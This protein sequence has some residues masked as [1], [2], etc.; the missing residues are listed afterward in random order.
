M[1]LV[2]SSSQAAQIK[3]RRLTRLQQII[4]GL[5]KAD[6][7]QTLER[8]S[9]NEINGKDADGNTVL[10]WAARSAN[11]AA[12]RSL[13]EQGADISHAS[14]FGSTAL[15]YAA[16]ARLPDCILPLLQAGA[17]A[18]TPNVC[19][20]ETPLHVAALRHDDPERFLMPLMSYGADINACDHEGSSVL[21]FAVQAGHCCSAEYLLAQGADVHR[22][23]KG[24]LT[25]I[26]VAMVYNQHTLIEMLFQHGASDL[27]MTKA[28]ETLLHLC[29][30]YGDL[31]TLALLARRKLNIAEKARD[32]HRKTAMDHA[33]LRSSE[34]LRAFEQLTTSLKS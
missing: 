15:H 8:A 17:N 31:I 26:G 1:S 3:N 32:A 2:G 18:N 10:S 11:E 34:I 33:Q 27:D 6:F 9:I 23:D 24:G 19:L 28:G 12:T 5:V 16:G 13:L 29:A 21:A 20:L 14:R 22:P 7:H 30:L 4:L 25:P